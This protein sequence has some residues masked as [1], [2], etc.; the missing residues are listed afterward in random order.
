M[1]ERVSGPED[2][3][4]SI[5]GFG[6]GRLP[7][8]EIKGEM[9]PC[10]DQIDEMIRYAYQHGVRYFDSA[11]LYCSGHC[12]E[13]VGKAVRDFR[14]KILL[15][16]KLQGED[17]KKGRQRKALE[18]TLEHL[19]T[20]YLD[21]YYF[22]GIN[23]RF[24]EEI[25]LKGGV[26]EDVFRMKQEG[27][28]R[29]MA[30]S[31]HG[32]PEEIR[33]I[34]DRAGE[35]DMPFD[36]C[37]MQY[38]MLDRRNEDMLQYAHQKKIGTFAMG[39][40]GGGRLA[41]PSDLYRRLKGQ[42]PKATYELALRFVMENPYMDCTL[43]GMENLD[44]VKE[45]VRIAETV[46][47]NGNMDWESMREALG[48]LK[49]FEELYCTGCRYCQPC[50]AGIKIQDIF[51]CYTFYNVYGL[52][53][54]GKSAY[55]EYIRRG[56]KSYRDCQNC[57]SCEKRCPQKLSIRKE[58]RRVDEKLRSITGDL[59]RYDPHDHREYL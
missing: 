34:I 39:P 28:I 46:E 42:E 19:Q 15:A 40:V 9:Y 52:G 6:T 50:P 32:E 13:A 45:N 31:F 51:K 20:D 36:A 25:L 18:R 43:S 22:W 10:Q 17:S 47:E 24:F 33:A 58:L 48:E 16:G 26:L 54:Y 12:E 2:T 29:N 27:L 44:M 57:G 38:N 56:G 21:Y 4:V 3:R 1:K 49:R 59:Y 8:K 41:A 5:L 55:L 11:P 14:K 53:G 7:E 23:Q 37:L 30:F 35:V